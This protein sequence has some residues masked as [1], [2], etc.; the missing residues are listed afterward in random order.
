VVNARR[1][2]KAFEV[3]AKN[4]DSGALQ[5]FIDGLN[6]QKAL[7]GV[8]FDCGAKAL[9]KQL[10]STLSGLYPQQA[11]A[12]PIAGLQLSGCPQR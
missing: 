2:A 6:G 11:L 5:F 12:L 4:Y 8:R 9:P 1:A 3:V 7:S 10:S